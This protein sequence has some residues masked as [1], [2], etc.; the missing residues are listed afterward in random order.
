MSVRPL[1]R[2]SAVL[3]LALSA[4]GACAAFQDKTLGQSIDETSAATQMTRM[5]GPAAAAVAVQ[6]TL[7]PLTT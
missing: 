3:I 4:L 7:R 2:L 1:L 6:R 5:L